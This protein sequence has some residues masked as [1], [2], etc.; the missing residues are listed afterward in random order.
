MTTL[1]YDSVGNDI[2]VGRADE[3]YL[4][5]NGFYN[6]AKGFDAV[7][8]YATAGGYDQAYLYD[9][10]GNDTLYGSSHYVFMQSST[11]SIY[12]TGFDYVSGVSV[13]GG[14]DRLQI[15][16]TDYYFSHYGDWN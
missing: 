2:F 6:Y 9:S 12:A 8:A 1:F 3:S 11:H 4:R 13:N 7:N 14:N 5:G 16:A 15:S 10:A